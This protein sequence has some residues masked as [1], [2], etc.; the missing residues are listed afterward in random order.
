M[1]FGAITPFFALVQQFPILAGLL[2]SK[3]PFG[4]QSF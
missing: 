1:I 4:P 2:N 3:V